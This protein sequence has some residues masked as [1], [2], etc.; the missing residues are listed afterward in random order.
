MERTK[1]AK[2]KRRKKKK[3]EEEKTRCQHL[4]V[5]RLLHLIGIGINI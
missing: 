5:Y 2:K 3:K 1:E 4:C